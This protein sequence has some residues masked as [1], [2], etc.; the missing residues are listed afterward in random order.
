MWRLILLWRA[1]IRGISLECSTRYRAGKRSERVSY[2]VEHSKKLHNFNKCP[3]KLSLWEKSNY[4]E[5]ISTVNFLHIAS[6][7]QKQEFL[8]CDTRFVLRLKL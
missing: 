8:L 7:K 6:Y 2:E 1:Q 3:N 5:N 4:D